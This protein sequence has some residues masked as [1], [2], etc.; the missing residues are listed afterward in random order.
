MP[1]LIQIPPPIRLTHWFVPSL[2]DVFFCALLFGFFLQPY[3]AGSLLSD[4]D[5]G[6]HIRTGEL[7]LQ[8]GSIPQSDPFSFTLPR[9]TWFAWEWLADVIFAL[10]WQWRGL[11]GVAAFSGCILGLAATALLARLLRQGSGLWIGNPSRRAT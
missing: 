1:R 8:T 5:T 2:L 11:A 10:L 3:G 7:A 6:W 4:G 9:K